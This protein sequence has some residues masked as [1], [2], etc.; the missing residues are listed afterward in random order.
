MPIPQTRVRLKGYVN[1]KA[2]NKFLDPSGDIGAQIAA[3][4][5]GDIIT[6][7]MAQKLM[8]NQIREENS[9]VRQFIVNPAAP[10]QAAKPAETFPGLIRYEL[11]LSRVDLYDANLFQAFKIVGRNIVDQFKPLILFVTQFAPEDPITGPLAIAN[12]PSGNPGTTLQPFQLIIPG[13]WFNSFPVGFD[14]TDT[15]QS[16]VADV[17]AIAQDVISG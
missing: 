15:N 8:I 6:I 17:E 9:F 4:P 14:I 3:I 13:V 11:Q 12:S 1:L 7:G 2:V 5:A 16:F 10:E